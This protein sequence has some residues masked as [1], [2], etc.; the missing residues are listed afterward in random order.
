MFCAAFMFDEEERYKFAPDDTVIAIYRGVY[1]SRG[2]PDALEHPILI[3]A[4]E[5]EYHLTF[6]ATD[7]EKVVSFRDIVT[8]IKNAQSQKPC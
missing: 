4:I 3:D 7:L 2:T 5:K 1:P 8:G 6:D